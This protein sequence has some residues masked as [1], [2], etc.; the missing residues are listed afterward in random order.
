MSIR[1]FSLITF[2]ITLLAGL[3]LAAVFAWSA[4][5]QDRTMVT[6]NASQLAVQK[7][8]SIGKRV[9][10]ILTASDLALGSGETY[11]GR[12]ASEQSRNLQTEVKQLANAGDLA[13]AYLQGDAF[14]QALQ[15]LSQLLDVQ[16]GQNQ[17]EA[18]LA[19]F[20]GIA[21]EIVESYSLSLNTLADRVITQS[22]EAA[23]LA[24]RLWITEFVS[25][26]LFALACLGLS[27]INVILVISPIERIEAASNKE[28]ASALTMGFFHRAPAE[29]QKLASALNRYVGNLNEI[30]SERTESLERQ[31]S[32]L[33][34][35][36][37]RREA[38]EIELSAALKETER[39]SQAK[40]IFLSVTSHE[41]R[42]PLNTI[43]ST[44]ELLDTPQLSADK[45]KYW[46]AARSAGQQMSFLLEEVLDF[47]SIDSGNFKLRQETVA[48]PEWLEEMSHKL[49][50]LCAHNATPFEAHLP[51]YLP[52]SVRLDPYRVQQIVDNFITNAIKFSAK[53]PV[54]FE[55]QQGLW[56]NEQPSLRLIVR[57][58]GPGIA[59]DD[60]KKIF[61]PF[62]QIDGSLG[63]KTGGVGLGLALCDAIAKAMGGTCGLE[64]QLGVGS[65]FSLTIPIETIESNPVATDLTAITRSAD[66]AVPSF[67]GSDRARK[68]LLVE[69]S[70]VNQMLAV[71][72][73]EQLGLE[74]ATADDGF[75]AVTLC[76]EQ[77]FDVI[78]M[79]LQMP[80]MDGFESARAI[81]AECHLNAHTPIIPLTAN[82][83]TEFRQQAQ[84]EG[85]HGFISKPVSLANLFAEISSALPT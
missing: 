72:L 20:D 75:A 67:A 13:V 78:L 28:D 66:L 64:S 80:G 9:D 18:S 47:S 76:G 19:E 52:A 70:A 10:V 32:D 41:L 5:T 62:T 30:V 54:F 65:S 48:L 69:D 44:M 40:S 11:T 46:N 7:L 37:E 45:Q 1:L 15:S 25:A 42:T 4:V 14:N 8:E 34:A 35:E 2:V 21:A 58:Q 39:A 55:V 77:S 83:G 22:G 29:I 38:A 3:A 51:P 23:E 50:A 24:D 79:D 12:W 53:S 16:S 74:V 43:M 82:V 59:P 31:K 33:V 85:M 26:C 49:S 57:D 63:R 60:Q 84:A 27:I 56:L 6:L 71:A 61:A 68:V 73:L 36:V 17:T 81:R